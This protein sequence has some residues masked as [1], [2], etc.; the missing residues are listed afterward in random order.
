M[1]IDYNMLLTIIYTNLTKNQTVVNKSQQQLV[2]ILSSL[3]ELDGELAT[4]NLGSS[5]RHLTLALCRLPLF[6]EAV[7]TPAALKADGKISVKVLDQALM[8]SEVCKKW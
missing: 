6:H 1:Y 8:E 7:M 3:I 2:S 5:L 4:H